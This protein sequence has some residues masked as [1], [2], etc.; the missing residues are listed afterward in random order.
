MTELE[1]LDKTEAMKYT[2]EITR[3][4]LVVACDVTP[5]DARNMVILIADLWDTTGNEL[6]HMCLIPEAAEQLGKR[7]LE[8]AEAVNASFEARNDKTH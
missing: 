6:V 2:N 1:N 4:N 3:A 8:S 7:L 5:S